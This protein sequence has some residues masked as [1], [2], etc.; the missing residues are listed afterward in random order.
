MTPLQKIAMGLVIVILP[1]NF[2]AH[3][4]PAWRFYDALPDPIGW[5]LVVAGVWALGR[6]SGLELASVRWLA[7]LA[8]L[9]S[10]PLWFPQLNHLLVPR[11]NPDITISGQ[12][13]I[14]LPQT[15]FSLFLARRI[16]A[17]GAA[18]EPRDRY[19]VSRFGVLSW[20]LVALVV[21]PIVAYGGG[22]SRLEGP[23]LVLIGLVNVAFVFYLFM[24][25]RR[26]FL[27][28]PGPREWTLRER[29]PED[30]RR[31]PPDG[32]RPS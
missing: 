6:S 12:W 7:A 27:G 4:H 32:E 1:A 3:P 24:V 11:Y 17:A 10:V 15:L 28:G 25:H 20:G 9:V 5:V 31:P 26:E 22:A 19:V 2:P 30:A 16:R 23:T 13:A 29:L 18:A 21:L 14:S 8:L